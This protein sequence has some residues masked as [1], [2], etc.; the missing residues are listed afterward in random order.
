M[1][2]LRT[3]HLISKFRT[4]IALIGLL[5]IGVCGSH[6]AAIPTFSEKFDL[7]VDSLP[8]GWNNTSPS[9]STVAITEV[10]SSYRLMLRRDKSSQQLVYFSGRPES[11]SEDGMFSNF[12]SSVIMR[13]GASA[14]DRRGI[15]ARASN[16][17]GIYFNGYSVYSHSQKLIIAK[18]PKSTAVDGVQLGSVNLTLDMAP[19]TDYL[20]N[21]TAN[22]KI[23]TAS[24]FGRDN[25]QEFT[26]MLGQLSIEDESYT[27]GYYGFR[28][29]PGADG[30]ATYYSDLIIVTVPEA[31]TVS[32]ALLGLAVLLLR[33]RTRVPF[34]KV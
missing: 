15:I 11:G 12:E 30:R 1:K 10:A 22:G 24:I 13:T 9:V 6:A 21:F 7:P 31:S 8:A 16:I 27:S 17:N 19:N 34:L 23:L 2:S 25:N 4:S 5:L 3:K 14:T 26:I 29:F 32:F 20:F 33:L 18:D 28:N